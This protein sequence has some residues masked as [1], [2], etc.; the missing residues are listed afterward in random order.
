VKA[1]VFLLNKAS[2]KPDY[3][4]WII[5]SDVTVDEYEGSSTGGF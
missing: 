1:K 5:I 2:E 4:A 3:S